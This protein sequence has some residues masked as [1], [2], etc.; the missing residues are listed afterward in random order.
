MGYL[1]QKKQQTR[2]NIF[3]WFMVF[4]LGGL[5]IFS[6]TDS[7]LGNIWFNL[8]HLFCL[9]GVIL[10]YCLIIKKYKIAAYFGIIFL[11]NYTSLSAAANIFISDGFDGKESFNLT[12]NPKENLID[13]LPVDQ[14]EAAGTLIL[15]H[16][17]QAAYAVMGY[18]NRLT[19]IRIDLKEIKKKEYPLIFEHLREFILLQDNPVIVFGEFGLPAWASSF[20]KFAADTGL[21]VKNKLVFTKGSGFNIFSVPSFYIL[22]FQEMGISQITQVKNNDKKVIEATISFTPEYS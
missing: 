13:T 1:S 16:R 9:S 22:G 3:L 11:I 20:K 12:F 17:Y 8:F 4:F 5:T 2:K 10:L 21:T 6:L 7:R 15:A 19:L 18:K 14:I